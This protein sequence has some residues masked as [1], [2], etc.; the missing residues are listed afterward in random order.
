MG[1]ANAHVSIQSDQVFI[2]VYKSTFHIE[3]V[4]FYFILIY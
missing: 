2:I 1:N 3:D 4:F